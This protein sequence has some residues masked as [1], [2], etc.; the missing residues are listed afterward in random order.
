MLIIELINVLICNADPSSGIYL[1]APPPPDTSNASPR[2]I[3][4]GAL[5]ALQGQAAKG[6]G[7]YESTSND[8]LGTGLVLGDEVSNINN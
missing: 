5:E 3:N 4:N 2:S 8:Q 6:L 7:G 1:S